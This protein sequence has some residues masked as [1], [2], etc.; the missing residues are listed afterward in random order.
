[1]TLCHTLPFLVT[2]LFAVSIVYFHI[3]PVHPYNLSLF[4]TAPPLLGDIIIFR[5]PPFR[6]QLYGY[7]LENQSEAILSIQRQLA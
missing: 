6:P 4:T 5:G 3:F 2:L 1:M 7:Y